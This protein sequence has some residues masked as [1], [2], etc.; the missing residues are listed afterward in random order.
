M[1]LVAVSVAGD[2]LDSWT[3]Y[4]FPPPTRHCLDTGYNG[5]QN[6]EKIRFH[7]GRFVAIGRECNVI[8]RVL[9]S[10]DGLNWQA[11]TPS[12]FPTNSFAIYGG[13][14]GVTVQSGF[15]PS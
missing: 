14:P 9:S 12:N 1:L 13:S 7:R 15:H 11:S 2:A 4:T 6:I 10:S 5:I 8:T 3:Q